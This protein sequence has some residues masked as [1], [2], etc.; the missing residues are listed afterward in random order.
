MSSDDEDMDA[1]AADSFNKTTYQALPPVSQAKY[2]NAYQVFQKWN[3]SNGWCAISEDLLMKYF[4]ELNAKSKPSTL[5]AIFSMLKATFR[6][7]DDI[8]IAK[9]SK[10]IEYIKGRNAS[11]K[12]AKA[13]IFTDEEIERFVNEAPDDRWLDVKVVCIFGVS[14]VSSSKKLVNVMVE[15]VKR[16][17]DLILVTIP[18]TDTTPQG[19]FTI[20]GTYFNIVQKYAN[21]R[22]EK[23]VSN[24]FFLAYNDGKCSSQPIGKNKF[25][26]MPRRVAMYLKLSEPRRYSASF[27][28]RR[29]TPNLYGNSNAW[30]QIT[31]TEQ[32]SDTV[33]LDSQTGH[34]KQTTT[35]SFARPPLPPPQPAVVRNTRSTNGN[36]NGN[37]TAHVC[38]LSCGEAKC[39]L[40]ENE[41]SILHTFNLMKPSEFSITD[42]TPAVYASEPACRWIVAYVH[43]NEAVSAFNAD[44]TFED[45]TRSIP[46]NV[47][48]NQKYIR[49]STSQVSAAY[50]VVYGVNCR[51]QKEPTDVCSYS[52]NDVKTEF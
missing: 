48:I 41:K 42:V 38:S 1:E 49:G 19:T 30:N 31:A 21:L 36:M 34:L 25:S 2:Q 39:A 6:I 33:E 35:F 37:E 8:D 32:S 15:H 17:D 40:D 46:S 29:N 3:K 11:Y 47:R 45:I 50:V 52:G 10:L 23:P 9:Y 26:G 28:F 24:R 4:V 43:N 5:F 22:H 51:C 16:Y 7:N 14:G 27:S 20:T 44:D 13:K 18:R 12:P